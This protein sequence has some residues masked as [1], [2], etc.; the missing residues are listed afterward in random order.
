MNSFKFSVLFL[1]LFLFLSSSVFAGYFFEMD[2][3]SITTIANIDGGPNGPSPLGVNAYYNQG[4]PTQTL[5]SLPNPDWIEITFTLRNL[6]TSDLTGNPRSVDTF[7]LSLDLYNIFDSSLPSFN[8]E[9][10]HSEA[11]M[12]SDVTI[13][14]FINI[15]YPASNSDFVYNA[16]KQFTVR[17]SLNNIVNGTAFNEIRAI[18]MP[19]IFDGS[20]NGSLV[21]EDTGTYLNIY[22]YDP[23]FV[24]P[25]VLHD[26]DV[27]LDPIT[28]INP[29]TGN[30]VLDGSL[31]SGNGTTNAIRCDSI[32]SN[33]I[34]YEVMFE[35]INA[36]HNAATGNYL[37]LNYFEFNCN[38]ITNPVPTER[39]DHFYTGYPGSLW[40]EDI[41]QYIGFPPSCEFLHYAVNEPGH[42][43][44]QTSLF[45]TFPEYSAPTDF[46]AVPDC[47]TGTLCPD[48]DKNIFYNV[49]FFAFRKYLNPDEFNLQFGDRKVF[50]G[51]VTNAMTGGNFRC[52]VTDVNYSLFDLTD[53]EI[54]T[55][56]VNYDNFI[57]DGSNLG[58]YDGIGN[59]V[60]R[61]IKLNGH[62]AFVIRTGAFMPSSLYVRPLIPWTVEVPIRNNGNPWNNATPKDILYVDVNIISDSW[63][64]IGQTLEIDGSVPE[65]TLNT[66]ENKVFVV[67]FPINEGLYH[68]F[69]TAA[70][71]NA[72]LYDINGWI[73]DL[74]PESPVSNVRLITILNPL[75]YE[76]L[77]DVCFTDP[78]WESLCWWNI[79]PYTLSPV[80]L[81]AGEDIEFVLRLRN[82]FDFNEF[83]D[84][85]YETNNSGNARLDFEPVSNFIP[86]F[87]T[88]MFG[89]KYAKLVLRNP[90]ILK[91]DTNYTV[92]DTSANYPYVWDSLQLEFKNFSHNLKIEN[93]SVIPEQNEYA[94]G[95]VLDFE[96]SITN[97]G[98]I[99]ERDINFLVVSSMDSTV[100]FYAPDGTDINPG[101][102]LTFTGTLPGIPYK[103]VFV[104]EATVEAVPFEFTTVDN[105][106]KI[107]ILTG[108]EGDVSALPETNY[109]L[110]IL[111]ALSV[112]FV[113]KKK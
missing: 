35:D 81:N 10:I 76:I 77:G 103:N 55:R 15:H 113:V 25:P 41:G 34:Y 83:F 14:R 46:T 56:T 26:L 91:Q 60:L 42:N 57:Y 63:S 6:S 39:I 44:C 111:I 29:L 32:D 90:R 108:Y 20:N 92:I 53:T 12:T 61:V 24:P 48:Q 102:T 105:S 67:S 27:Y 106:E 8:Y 78:N 109:V 66:D 73:F 50:K 74:T 43:D 71:M 98:N 79:M 47:P 17:F 97:T 31:G 65:Q 96:L 4:P 87:S 94:L 19:I 40:A 38:T 7:D 36:N 45:N 85:T 52:Y 72:K 28:C 112:L 100:S 93:F 99:I 2:N 62:D 110:L 86:P 75:V 59:Y 88:G 69:L 101:Q 1:S 13:D 51:T 18:G 5:E 80:D 89:Y 49:N 16:T 84:L 70:A 107:V 9:L 33:T 37:K 54:T 68:Q 22:V 21:D 82:P 95:D 3:V 64:I 30:P 23:N 58:L 104:I 11:D